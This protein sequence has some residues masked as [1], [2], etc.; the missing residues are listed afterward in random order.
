MSAYQ[1]TSD[2]IEK[3]EAYKTML[4]AVSQGLGGDMLEALKYQC[5]DHIGQGSLEKIENFHDLF[6]VLEQRDVVCAEDVDFLILSLE[7]LAQ[8][9]LAS[10]AERYKTEWI[11]KPTEFD[12]TKAYND[13]G[14]DGDVSLKKKQSNLSSTSETTSNQQNTIQSDASPFP[15]DGFVAEQGVLAPPINPFHEQLISFVSNLLTVDW[16]MT[17]R[18]MGVS[19]D[20]INAAQYNWPRDLRRQIYETFAEFS[21]YRASVLVCFLTH[22]LFSLAMKWHR[23]FKETGL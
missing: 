23:W 7:N 5:L 13:L 11:T 9:D 3:D 17:A 1:C 12:N 21:R 10:V 18:H 20:I 14:G 19:D 6:L 22:F 16:Q 4:D 8:N 15:T 2:S